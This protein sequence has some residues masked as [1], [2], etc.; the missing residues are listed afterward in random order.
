MKKLLIPIIV[1]TI[2]TLALAGLAY[3]Q[4]PNPPQPEYPEEYYGQ[5]MIGMWAGQGVSMG[6][7]G[8][9][10]GEPARMEGFGPMHDEM[11]AAFAQIF[12][13]SV[14]ELEARH[15][16]GETMWDMAEE[17]G[18]TPGQF[19]ELM[20]QARN[21]ALAQAAADGVIPQEQY[22]WMLERMNQMWSGENHPGLIGCDGGGQRGFSRN[23][24]L[25]FGDNTR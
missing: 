17:L 5:G 19:S 16:A 10:A 21:Q 24:G 20:I 7:G 18:L 8:W 12:D 11:M 14:D 13:L 25:M 3:A 6:G 4:A 2:L 9:R 22:N 23:G 1:I 15:D